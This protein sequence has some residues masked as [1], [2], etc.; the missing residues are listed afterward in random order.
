MLALRA[1]A[2]VA[3]LPPVP[4]LKGARYNGREQ[5]FECGPDARD[6]RALATRALLG[7]RAGQDIG[8]Y[9][10]AIR[11]QHPPFKA[12]VL[13]DTKVAL[14]A[15]AE[16]ATSSAIEVDAVIQISVSS[17]VT[18]AFFGQI[19]Y[20]AKAR[21]QTL[22][23]PLLPRLFHHLAVTHGGICIGDPVVMHAGVHIPHGTWS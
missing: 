14:R 3:R 7:I 19:C 2:P 22:R 20:R 4:G 1:V 5:R 13:A 12:A 15:G 10:A 11:R 21:C 23:I 17:I 8:W 6:V 9:W 16:S 18:D